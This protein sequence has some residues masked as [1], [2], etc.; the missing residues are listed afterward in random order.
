MEIYE[1]IEKRRSVRNFRPDQVPD[2]MLKKILI[3]GTQAPNAFNREPWEFIV[4]KDSA[5]KEAIAQMRIKV[6]PQ[7]RAI[8]TAPLLVVVCFNNELGEDSLAST[9]AC[10]ENMLLA[11]TSEGLGAVTL[12]FHGKKIKDLLNIPEGFDV[13]TVMPLGYPDDKTKK[14]ERIPADEKIHNNTF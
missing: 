5:L 7:K 6:P 10:I 1:A 3:A 4:V 12:T 13:A 8:D 2:K 14:P 11:A 9:Y